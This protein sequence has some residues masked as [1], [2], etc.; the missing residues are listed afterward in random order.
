MDETSTVQLSDRSQPQSLSANA[1]TS[2]QHKART[3]SLRNSINSWILTAHFESHIASFAC[4]ISQ[5]WAWVQSRRAAILLAVGTFVGVLVAIIALKPTFEG[6]D[7]SER[8]LALAE[9]TALKDFLSYCW[10]TDV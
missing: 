9:W 8:A 10:D 4:R 3:T 6:H 1:T 2:T 5:G 7:A